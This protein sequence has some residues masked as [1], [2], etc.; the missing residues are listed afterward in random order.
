MVNPSG[1]SD[2]PAWLDWYGDGKLD[3]R[4]DKARF[5]A[6]KNGVADWNEDRIYITSK[7]FYRYKNSNVIKRFMRDY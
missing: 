7:E 3:T 5:D 4:E 2:V 6:D 1:V